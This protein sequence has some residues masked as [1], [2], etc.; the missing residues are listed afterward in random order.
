MRLG[1]LGGT[2]DPVHSGHLV[3][4][5]EVRCDLELDNVVFVPTGLPW[6]K[7]GG[8]LSS[9][10]HRLAMLQRATSANPQFHVS[11]MELDRSGYTYTVD[12]LVELKRHYGETTELFFILGQDAL[13]AFLRWKEPRRVLDLCRLVVVPRSGYVQNAPIDIDVVMPEAAERLVWVDCT[14][15]GISATEIRRRVAN[16]LSVRHLTPESVVNYIDEH[17]LYKW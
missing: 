9:G 10:Q 1:I 16:N 13:H 11:S 17:G 4:A 7:A 14:R 3:V 2:F 6:M 12:T 8:Y 5:E 15:I